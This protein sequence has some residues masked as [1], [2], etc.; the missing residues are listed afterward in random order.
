[1]MK[2]VIVM[3]TDLNMPAG[4]MIAQGAHASSNAILSTARIFNHE[5]DSDYSVIAIPYTAQ[6]REWIEN[7]SYTKICLA[8]NS[9]AE[10]V[11][12]Y[13]KAAQDPNL[14]VAMI[15]DNGKTIFN[16]VPTLTCC[17]IGPASAEVIDKFTGWLQLL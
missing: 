17:A 16:G 4:K 5:E 1:M 6:M 12:I 11:D 13:N 15:K 7:C 9:E 3:R 14:P 10:L 8:V 2:Q